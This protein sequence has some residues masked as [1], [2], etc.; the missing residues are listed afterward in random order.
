MISHRTSR[1]LDWLFFF[2]ADVQTVFGPFIAVYLTHNRWTQ[3]ELGLALG[4]GTA[5]AMVAQLPAGLLVDAL[6]DKAAA[7]TLALVGI[8][9]SASLMASSP[10][11][12]PVM[13]AEVVY[14]FSACMLYPALAAL[15][16]R[17]VETSAVAER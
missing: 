6:R 11:F 12:W 15:T 13:L 9:V 16:L 8:A 1:G 10:S 5:S 2:V 4:V 14:G 7:A 3:A 17:L